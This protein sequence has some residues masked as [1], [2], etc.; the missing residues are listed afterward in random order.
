MSANVVRNVVR[1][2]LNRKLLCKKGSTVVV[3]LE[4][5]PVVTRTLRRRHFLHFVN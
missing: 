5:L 3:A 1:N 4:Q 2:L